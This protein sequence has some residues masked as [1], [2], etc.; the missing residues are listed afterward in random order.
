VG[1]SD[2][3]VVDWDLKEN[4]FDGGRGC[5]VRIGDDDGEQEIRL[6]TRIWLQEPFACG[7]LSTVTG[8]SN[9]HS[10]SMPKF[11]CGEYAATQDAMTPVPKTDRMSRHRHQIPRPL[12]HAALHSV[13]AFA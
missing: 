6:R 8:N 2:Q 13:A 12:E 10:K 4:S 11:S 1:I 3:N 9:L 5:V 7:S